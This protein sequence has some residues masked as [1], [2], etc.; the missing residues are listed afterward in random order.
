LKALQSPASVSFSI[1]RE[2]TSRVL[3]AFKD[4]F[5]EHRNVEAPA[6]LA[7]IG[8]FG[9]YKR[10][11]LK[12]R[13]DVFLDYV[14]T[15]MELSP[16]RTD[17]HWRQQVLNLGKPDFEL[18]FIGTLENLKADLLTVSEMSGVRLPMPESLSQERRNRSGDWDFAP[19]REQIRRIEALYAPDFEAFGY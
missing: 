9:F 10:D 3:S 17:R 6:H 13:F 16:L 4:F 7:A 14:A 2:P 1:V 11:D 8:A 5:V 18:T 15:S 12:F 19:S